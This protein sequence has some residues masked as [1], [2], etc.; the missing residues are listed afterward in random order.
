M[1]NNKWEGIFN[2]YGVNEEL[3]EKRNYKKN[4]R[5]GIT[6]GFYKKGDIKYIDTY[7]NGEKIRRRYY[8]KK[9]K[10]EF[11]QTYPE[12]RAITGSFYE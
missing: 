12:W 2:F 11:D 7:K 4:K 10:L 3:E 6:K 8:D 1:K 9:G 5:N